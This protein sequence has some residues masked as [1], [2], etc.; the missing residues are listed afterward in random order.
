MK[1]NPPN[2]NSLGFISVQNNR[3]RILRIMHHAQR[4]QS[5]Y[6]ELFQ[7]MKHRSKYRNK[8][9]PALSHAEVEQIL[10]DMQGFWVKRDDTAHNSSR[11]VSSNA[12][13]QAFVGKNEQGEIVYIE[14]GIGAGDHYAA[15]VVRKAS[16][17]ERAFYTTGILP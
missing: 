5:A 3:C 15:T 10:S 16:E 13:S 17:E 1:K 2:P 14:F 8:I 4:T 9:H 11:N 6:K 7:V 12:S